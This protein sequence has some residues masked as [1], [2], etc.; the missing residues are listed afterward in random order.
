VKTRDNE[1]AGMSDA[2]QPK[3]ASLVQAGAQQ[4][5]AERIND[6]IFMAKDIS[7]AY[8]VRT[9]GGDVLVNAGFKDSVERNK[10]AFAPVRS[11]PLKAIFL[12][13]AHIDHFGGVP[14][15]REANTH[16]IAQQLF[17]DTAAYFKQLHPYIGRRTAKLWSITLEILDSVGAPIPD[18]VPDITFD[19]WYETVIGKRRFQAISTPGGE[20]PDACVVW[21]PDDKILFSGNLFGPVF[22]SVPNLNTIRGDKPRSVERFLSS[23]EKV[24]QLGAELL[25]TGHG[26]PIIGR[27][28]IQADLDKLHAAVSYIR[29]ATIDGMNSGKDVHTLMREI[30]LPQE[31]MLGEFHGKV[32]WAVKSIWH[33]YSGWFM[34]DATTS[35]YAVPR[36]SVDADLVELAGADALAERA[37][38]KLAAGNPLEAMHLIDIVLAVAPSHTAGLSV[39]LQSLQQLLKA[40]CGDNL[41]EVMWLRSEIA[42]AENAQRTANG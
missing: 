24:R 6:F 27:E 28:R 35:L 34:Y 32:S 8:L 36:S 30:R 41:S 5:A 33:E 31:L 10:A 38:T 42:L 37:R 9:N 40:S 25:I 20:A 11:G 2:Q 16:V 26:D 13:Q 23:L 39:K 29:R 21:L 12:T 18:V 19:D 17:T 14:G 1:A 3:L 15:L 7:N 4:T 22:M